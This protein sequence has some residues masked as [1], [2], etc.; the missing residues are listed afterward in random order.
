MGRDKSPRNRC[1]YSPPV[2]LVSATG[3]SR[4]PVNPATSPHAGTTG[5]S[6]SRV[7]GSPDQFVG[8]RPASAVTRFPHR[9]GAPQKRNEILGQ[10][11]ATMP[12]STTNSTGPMREGRGGNT[13]MPE[14][15]F[16]PCAWQVCL[17][18]WQCP[19]KARFQC[20]TG[21][22]KFG[23]SSFPNLTDLLPNAP[24]PQRIARGSP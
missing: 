10:C 22:I 12:A 6:L 13:R 11:N 8:G 5:R 19:K 4:V 14:S 18:K 1:G 23:P 17:R 24:E 20:P 9:S 7:R 15:Q 3:G 2:L 16:V 21:P